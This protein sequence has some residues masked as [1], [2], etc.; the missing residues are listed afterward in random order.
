VRKPITEIVEGLSSFRDEGRAGKEGREGFRS[1][2]TGK[3]SLLK[4]MRFGGRLFIIVKCIMVIKI[5]Q[6]SDLIRRNAKR[7]YGL[8]T[9]GRDGIG[10]GMA[11]REKS[12]FL[13]SKGSIDGN[14]PF[15]LMQ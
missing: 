5:Q 7:K 8:G 12:Y 10:K 9:E 1:V 3:D 14:S 15:R 4:K 11:L 6:M 2:M 13:S